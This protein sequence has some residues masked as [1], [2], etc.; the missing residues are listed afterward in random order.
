[1]KLSTMPDRHS[2]CY[3]N[4]WDWCKLFNYRPVLMSF[5]S[6]SPSKK[7]V[8][9]HALSNSPWNAYYGILY[10]GSAVTVSMP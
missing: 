5:S 3:W 9:T 8:K 6:T 2:V 7:K 4:S 1:M 10:M